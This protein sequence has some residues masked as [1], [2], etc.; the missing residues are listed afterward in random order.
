L[1][2]GKCRIDFG[3]AFVGTV[4]ID[5]LDLADADLLVDARPL[6]GGG[7]RRSNRATN[8][9]DLLVLL[10]HRRSVGRPEHGCVPER[11]SLKIGSFSIQVNANGN[12][13]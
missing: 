6:L 9:G 5:E 12:R 8:G 10:L 13:A 2:H 7:L 1:R 4:F 11:R 3:N